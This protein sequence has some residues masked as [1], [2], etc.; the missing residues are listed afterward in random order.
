MPREHRA[1]AARSPAAEGRRGGQPSEG[2]PP[3]SFAAC[4]TAG[5]PSA[6][7]GPRAALPPQ[8]GPL[9]PSLS[10]PG[11]W[12]RARRSRPI[13]K[14]G[15]GKWTRTQQSPSLQLCRSHKHVLSCAR[16]HVRSQ[17]FSS[18][19]IFYSSFLSFV[20]SYRYV[21]QLYHRVSKI[22]W[23]YECEP[24]VIRG[25][26]LCGEGSTA[27]REHSRAGPPKN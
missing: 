15:R 24:G 19:L 2:Q 20:L 10:S 27:A 23:D 12:R 7:I 8:Q 17:P 6:G 22:E 26:I 3:I 25:S 14:H 11:S 5:P 16:A 18:L 9:T 1:A 4:G 13:W 21:A